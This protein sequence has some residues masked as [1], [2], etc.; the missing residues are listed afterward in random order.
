MLLFSPHYAWYILW[1]V[2]FFT[3]VPNLPMLV[4]LM[5]FFYL[6]TTSYAVP[7]PRMFFLNTILYGATLAAFA[8]WMAT[9]RWRV[10]HRFFPPSGVGEASA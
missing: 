6:D 2:P 5:G 7:G 4:Y 3:L 10:L 8:V 9:R 1:L